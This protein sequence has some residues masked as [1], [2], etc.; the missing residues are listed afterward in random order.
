MADYSTED[1]HALYAIGKAKEASDAGCTVHT[2]G[3]GA[4]ADRSLLQAIAHVGGG[5]FIDI[6]GGTSVLQMEAE[7]RAAFGQI[8][9]ELPPPKLVYED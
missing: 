3:V 8:A 4:N 2:M 1:K 6:P 5:M 7:V 9:A